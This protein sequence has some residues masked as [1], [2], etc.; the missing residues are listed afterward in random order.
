MNN[1][2][3]IGSRPD[4]RT[5][6]ASMA[7]AA[8]AAACQPAHAVS[9]EPM[10]T[11]S[12]PATGEQIP[13]IGLGTWQTFDVGVGMRASVSDVLSR[14]VA[15]G[16]RLVDT[17]PMYG[18]AEAVLGALRAELSPEAR[19]FTATKVWT[20][21]EAEGIAQMRQSLERLGVPRVDLMQVH[22][23]IDVDTH[24]ATIRRWKGEGLVRYAGVTHYQASAFD[25]LTRHVEG[26]I[27]FVQLNYSLG[28]RAAENR[29]LPAAKDRGVAVIVN[30][31]FGGG[32]LFDRVRATPLPSWACEIDCRS[33]AQVM[34]KYIISH[35]A[36]TCV[37]P[38]TSKVR[39]LDDNMDAG[40]GPLPDDALR[41]RMAAEFDRI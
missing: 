37:I 6:L 17:S 28:D 40:T 2:I 35:P 4:R 29:L 1:A 33:W 36:V 19:L 26:S 24:L 3:D 8:M 11:R 31:P 41:R 38:A 16:G 21:G 30:Q 20:S 14:F 34:L 23:L 9:S 25:R 12:I 10:K 32:A 18:S 22:N 39:H 15:R 27:D 7:A 5:F 13:V